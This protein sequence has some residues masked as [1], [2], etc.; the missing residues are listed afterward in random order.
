MTRTEM[1]E[2]VPPIYAQFI[3]GQAIEYLK[4]KGDEP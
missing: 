4:A 3:G 1:A 2:A